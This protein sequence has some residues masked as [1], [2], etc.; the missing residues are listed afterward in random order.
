[1]S[2]ESSITDTQKPDFIYLPGMSIGTSLR[3]QCEG[4][5]SSLSYMIGMDP[6]RFLIIQA[7]N[8]PDILSKRYAKNHVVI[9]YLFSGSVYAFRCTLL[10]IVKEVYRFLILSY[11]EAIEIINLRRH[12]RI[13]CLIAAEVRFKGQ[14]YRGIVSDISK[15]GCSFEFDR[16]EKHDFPDLNVQ[17]EIAVSLRLPE[18][19]EETVFNSVVRIVRTDRETMISGLQFIPSV[20][21]ETD[22][23]SET[24]LAAYLSTLRNGGQ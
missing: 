9:S 12:E 18:K 22:L 4:I 13:S 1:M 15:G 20:N 16:T 8:L 21:K 10:S 24:R 3:V 17:D 5:G 6:G 14:V 19:T 2:Q 11:P 23:A 7:P